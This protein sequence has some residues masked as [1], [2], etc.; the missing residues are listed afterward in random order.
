MKIFVQNQGQIELTKRHFLS[1]GGEG[2]IYVKGK[3]AY[4]IYLDPSKVIPQGKIQE[5]SALTLPN[6]I[7]PKLM[8]FEGKNIPIGYT[9]DFVK[10][11]EPICKLFTKSFQQRNH[12]NSKTLIDTCKNV[13]EIVEH[14]HSKN[15]LIV[16]LNELN[17]LIDQK[18]FNVYAIDVNTYQTPHYPATAIMDN[19]RDRHTTQFTE[20]SDWFS[21]GI[22]AFQILIG[23]HPYKGKYHKKIKGDKLDYRMTNNISVFDSNVT[24]PKVCHSLNTIPRALRK[25]F[26]YTFQRGERTIP[27]DNYEV[28]PVI[29]PQYTTTID[30][31]QLKVTKI[32]ECNREILQLYNYL[33][34]RLVINNG[35]IN[36]NGYI[37]KIPKSTQIGYD[38]KNNRI[39]GVQFEHSLLTVWDIQNPIWKTQY[40]VDDWMISDGRIYFQQDQ[41]IWEIEVDQIL[42]KTYFSAKFV[43]MSVDTGHSQTHISVILQNLLGKWFASIF[44]HSGFCKQIRLNELDNYRVIDGKYEGGVLVIIALNN[45]SQQYDRF[46]TRFNDKFQY[47]VRIE[48]DVPYSG[49]N[50]CVLQDKRICV[51]INEDEE[52]EI[53][54]SNYGTKSIRKIQDDSISMDMKLVS[55]GG[56]VEFFKDKNIFRMELV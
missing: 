18:F 40:M 53:F 42:G 38:P 17:F 49:I 9:M 50:F 7:R 22:I 12:I 48:K 55:N 27:P 35:W 28:V 30:S 31:K 41:K 52:L 11:T 8:L 26:V 15:I 3:T 45:S 14:C 23:I 6:I 19:I 51:L 16:D 34:N 5:L 24:L 1:Q 20:K 47:D 33:G 13:Q 44:P 29:S 36:H 37:S 54:S 46:V 10:H 32:F 39:V 4:K 2:Q 56:F 25:W 21:W 43:G